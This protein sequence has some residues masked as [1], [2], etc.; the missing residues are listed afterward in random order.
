MEDRKPQ[1]MDRYYYPDIVSRRNALSGAVYVPASF[2]S[3]LDRDISNGNDAS[4]LQEIADSG[5][6]D[7]PSD[8]MLE[9][10]NDYKYCRISSE[11]VKEMMDVLGDSLITDCVNEK[12]KK[13]NSFDDIEFKDGHYRKIKVDDTDGVNALNLNCDIFIDPKKRIGI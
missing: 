7:K 2:N 12:G 13:V 8:M 6:Y 9:A 3:Y 10:G 11:N 4:I 1:W 5:F